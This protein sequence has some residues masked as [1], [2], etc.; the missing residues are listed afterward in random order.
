MQSN[1]FVAHALASN[2]DAISIDAQILSPFR[3]PHCRARLGLASGSSAQWRPSVVL[4]AVAPAAINHH[5]IRRYAAPKHML[6]RSLAAMTVPA[7][8]D[9]S[10]WTTAGSTGSL[11]I[12]SLTGKH[13]HAVIDRVQALFAS[14]R[15]VEKQCSPGPLTTI[16]L[17]HRDDDDARPE[18]A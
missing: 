9:L 18:Q 14:G 3:A 11:F 6:Q 13:I 16:N 1:L 8:S 12:M 2:H 10:R 4:Q 17:N 5:D 7:F 15:V